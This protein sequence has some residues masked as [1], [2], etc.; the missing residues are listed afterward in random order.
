MNNKVITRI[1]GGLGNQLFCYA[2]ARRLALANN[3]ELII[4]DV[5]GFLHDHEYQRNYQLDHFNILCRKTE[6]HERLEP[7]SRWRR[8]LK[9][10]WNQQ[11]PYFKRTYIQQ[12]GV[13]FDERLLYVKLKGTTY[14]E[15]YWQSENYFKDIEA[16]IRS[17]LQITPP[18]DA[19][20]IAISKQMQGCAAI[21]VH[22]RFFDEPK[23]SC[24]ANNA[25]GS[26]YLRAIEKMLVEVPDAYFFVFSDKIEVARNFIPTAVKNITFL[27]HN[28][29]DKNAY[30]DLWLMTQCK[31]FIIANSTFS[32]WGAWLAKNPYKKVIA[33]GFK[34]QDGKTS[35]GFKGLLPNEWIKL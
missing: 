8:Y 27:S 9:R 13:D 28:V 32:W 4:D 25:P 33:P 17:D 21:A 16:T 12:Q 31:H 18:T 26:F 2:A 34:I 7:F 11:L 20:N 6:A 3:G 5:S 19:T 10:K 29:G 14:L 24:G 1:V 15:G 23:T 30:A 35:W 22:I